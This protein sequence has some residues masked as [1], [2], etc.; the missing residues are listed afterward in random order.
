MTEKN[1]TER[2]GEGADARS[3]RD[4]GHERDQSPLNSQENSECVV[5]SSAARRMRRTRER[6]RAGVM[7][8]P[9][10]ANEIV[11]DRLVVGGW[12][13]RELADDQAAICR[14]LERIRTPQELRPLEFERSGSRHIAMVSAVRRET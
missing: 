12:L 10:E 7:W 3:A 14:A 13:A 5:L 8:L 2:E 1:S 11:V 6:R 4:G 9:I